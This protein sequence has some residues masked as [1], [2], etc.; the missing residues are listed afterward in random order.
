MKL[1]RRAFDFKKIIFMLKGG[2]KVSNIYKWDF[3]EVLFLVK[4]PLELFLSTS[5]ISISGS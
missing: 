1:S 2:H 3:D 4:T 5:K